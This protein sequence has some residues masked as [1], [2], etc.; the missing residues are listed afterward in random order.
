MRRF[1]E[2]FAQLDQTTST[3]EKVA[4]IEAYFK[5][6]DPAD[7]AWALHLLSGGRVNVR[8]PRPRLASWAAAH[9]SIAP[10]L[11]AECH[12]AAG[13]FAETV[14]LLVTERGAAARA[15]DGPGVSLQSWIED[16]LLPL[17]AM[18][19]GEQR[20]CVQAWWRALSPAEVFLLTKMM[21]G[22]LRVGV[23]RGLVT[24]ALAKA[25]G[26]DVNDVAERLMGPFTPSAQA[27]L[28]L[29]TPTVQASSRPLPFFLA[30]SLSLSFE[31]LGPVRDWFIE[32]KWDGIRAQLIVNPQRAILWS[33]GEELLSDRFPEIVESAARLRTPCILDGELL[34]WRNG[35]PLPFGVLQRR[36][37]RERLTSNIRT[38]AP[39]AFVAYDLLSFEGQDVRAL[40]HIDRRRLLEQCLGQAP[41]RLMTSELLS[42]SSWEEASA[43][44]G[45]SRLRGVEGLMLKRR[46]APYGVG[47]VRGDWWKW[48]VD[49]L[50]IDAVLVHA[51]PGRGRRAGLLTD[52]TFALWNQGQLVPV[53]KA[54]SGLSEEEIIRLDRWLR[55]HSRG[56][57]GPVRVVEP[58]Q[59]FELGFE[60]VR[61]STRHR[62]G[63]AVR[64]PR[65]LRWRPDKPAHEADSIQALVALARDVHDDLPQSGLFGPV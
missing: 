5:S 11:F 8:L 37:S 53:A 4:A 32:W 64:F 23:S 2:L 27:F 43:C 49:P 62:S 9:A 40:P 55:S 35:K 41:P 3:L 63:I 61:R 21:T 22:G 51:E 6:A 48:K 16:R 29:R 58:V 34:A 13:D 56:R 15:S 1:A 42:V 52:Y 24:Q 25:L 19:P 36:I 17:S 60:D 65:I 26:A 57:F 38:L 39:V 45:T 54:Y 20:E 31:E 47:R 14:A 12:A 44:R 18:S 50:T 7:A 28:A 33:R 10:W 59:V 30:S 46:S